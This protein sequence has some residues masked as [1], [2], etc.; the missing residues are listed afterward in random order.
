VGVWHDQRPSIRRHGD[1]CALAMHAE[2]R[3]YAAS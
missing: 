3:L 1:V 2:A